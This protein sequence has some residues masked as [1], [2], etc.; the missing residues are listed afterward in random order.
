MDACVSTNPSYHQ[1]TAQEEHQ[2]ATHPSQSNQTSLLRKLHDQLLLIHRTR[3]TRGMLLR[4]QQRRNRVPVP[5]ILPQQQPTRL[6]IRQRV[7]T[8]NSQEPRETLPW[9]TDI[10]ETIRWVRLRAVGTR[11]CRWWWWWRGGR[12]WSRWH[13]GRRPRRALVILS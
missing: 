10:L 3:I 13:R 9:K 1:P 4:Y 11:F 2:K 7:Q 5:L 6:P 12:G 8:R